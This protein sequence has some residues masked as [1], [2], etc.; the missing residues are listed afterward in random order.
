[1]Q[2]G[3][4]TLSRGSYSRHKKGRLFRRLPFYTILWLVAILCGSLVYTQQHHENQRRHRPDRPGSLPTVII[5]P[6]GVKEIDAQIDSRHQT[7]IS[8]DQRTSLS[9]VPF[10]VRGVIPLLQ[11][12]LKTAPYTAYPHQQKYPERYDDK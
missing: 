2:R 9:A 8:T 10:P 4:K 7:P 3:P 5:A 6:G 12:L 11:Q 1:M